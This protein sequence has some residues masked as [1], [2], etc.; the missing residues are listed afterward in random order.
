MFAVRIATD[1]WRIVAHRWMQLLS[2]WIAGVVLRDLILSAAA[3]VAGFSPFLAVLVLSLAMLTRLTVFVAMLIVV[4][5]ELDGLVT[6]SEQGVGG[7]VR[8]VMGASLP[9]A[10]FYYVSGLLEQDFRAYLELAG[11]IH[12]WEWAGQ[13]P[14]LWVIGLNL[15]TLIVIAVCLALRLAWG[16]FG[17]RL[18]WGLAG[19][20]VLLEVIWVFFT[21]F[22]LDSGLGVVEEWLAGRQVGVWFEDARAALAVIAAPL[23]TVWDAIQPLVT[24]LFEAIFVPVAWMLAAATVY[25]QSLEDDEA[26]A[27]RPRRKAPGVV[28][29]GGAVVE[30]MV[31]QTD[32]LRS[33][34]RLMRRTGPLLIAAYCLIY[35]LIGLMEPVTL[36]F[37]SRLV[38]PHDVTGILGSFVPVLAL[39]PTLVVTPLLVALVA[40]AC[41]AAVGRLRGPGFG[42]PAGASARDQEAQGLEARVG[43]DVDGDNEVVGHVA[44]HEEDAAQLGRV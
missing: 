15:P 24:I 8:T 26:A 22:A 7:F 29:V 5:D 20:V 44:G 40:A 23:V 39:V 11:A 25:G 4:R 33:G 38:G 41:N 34:W 32:T 10:V 12:I 42:R 13:Q 16:R 9:F 30:E 3:Q 6:E 21:E 36:W 19:V 2:W 35:A 43:G 17:G 27:P 1:I 37:V 18:W 31:D 14:E 28:K